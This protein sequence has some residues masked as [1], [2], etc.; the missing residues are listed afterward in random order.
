MKFASFMA[1]LSLLMVGVGAIAS[2]QAPTSMQMASRPHR[3][4]TQASVSADATQLILTPSRGRP[5]AIAA[6]SLSAQMLDALDCQ[7]IDLSPSQRLRGQRFFPEAVAIDPATG[8]V[9]VGV[10][11]QSCIETDVSAVFVID[12]EGDRYTTHLVQVPGSRILPNA[13]ATFPLNSI[14]H[15]GYFDGDLLVKQADASGSMAILVFATPPDVPVGQ[16][17][18]CV[19][20]A[21][22]EGDRLCPPA[23]VAN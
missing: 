16:Y 2:E 20:T 19:Y 21:L 14:V 22:E 17:A 7:R 8:N 15:I 4:S 9:A 23:S 18:G 5:Q 13:T 12:P 6:S 1:A 11:L 10:V 3:P